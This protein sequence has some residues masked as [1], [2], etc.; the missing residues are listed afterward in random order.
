MTVTREGAGPHAFCQE[1]PDQVMEP[2]LRPGEL[3]IAVQE[4]HARALAVPARLL[5]DVR[6]GLEDGVEPRF[7]VAGLIADPG[8]MFQVCGHLPFVPGKRSGTW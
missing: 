5:G 6:I 4:R 7:G 3:L 1:V 8:E 2:T